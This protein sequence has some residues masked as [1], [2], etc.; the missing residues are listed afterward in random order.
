MKNSGKCRLSV[1]ITLEQK[2]EM[3]ERAKKEF[4]KFRNISEVTRAAIAEFL[5]S[6]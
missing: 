4:P 5:N 6:E 1:Q 2:K 3:E